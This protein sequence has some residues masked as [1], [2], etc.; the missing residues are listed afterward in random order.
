MKTLGGIPGVA[1]AGAGPADGPPAR[2]VHYSYGVNGVQYTA[3]QD[4]GPLAE[5]VGDDPRGV[6]GSVV[7]KVHQKNPYNSI[8]I[9]EEWSGLRSHAQGAAETASIKQENAP[10]V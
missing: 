2:L 1:A 7:V 10:P 8:V 6:V 9:C 4:V 3:C 5:T